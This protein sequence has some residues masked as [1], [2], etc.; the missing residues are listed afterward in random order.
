MERFSL[1]LVS[2]QHYE[3]GFYAA[4]G[5]IATSFPDLVV[6]VGD[7]I[8]EYGGVAGRLREH[9]GSEIKTLWDYRNRY[10]QYKLDPQ[11]QAAHAISP[12]LV[13]PDDHEI[14]NNWAGYVPE[15]PEQQTEL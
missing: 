6:H 4:Y 9:V 2:C 10:A 1:A 12:W 5:D 13:S 14:D 8:Y 15:D 11:L 3:A 7:Y